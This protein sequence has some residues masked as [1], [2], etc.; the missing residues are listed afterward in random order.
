MPCVKHSQQSLSYEKDPSQPIN[1][2][3]F[4][5]AGLFLLRSIL[6]DG[7]LLQRRESVSYLS[8]LCYNLVGMFHSQKRI[9]WS[10][11][12]NAHIPVL[13]VI[14]VFE[15]KT[16]HRHILM[17]RIRGVPLSSAFNELSQER[18]PEILR[19]LQKYIC[20]LRSHTP[21]RPGYVGAVDFTALHDEIVHE[22][23]F[24]PFD[25][26][27]EFHKALRRGIEEKS[28]HT[29][30]DNMIEMEKSRDY[31]CRMTHG[32]LSFRNIIIQGEKLTGIVDWET[33]G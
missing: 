7:H 13:R 24:G 3:L 15:S 19:Q 18:Q 11:C 5:R 32:G 27:P 26:V 1:D 21:P 16:G 8:T 12:H 6:K 9:R 14:T 22:G 33:S 28:G 25:S 2:T 20:A 29:E 4:Q 10:L 17:T 30:L 31:S 23:P